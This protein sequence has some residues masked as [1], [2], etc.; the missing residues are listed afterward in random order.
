MALSQTSPFLMY[1]FVSSLNA[2][3]LSFFFTVVSIEL[4]TLPDLGPQMLLVKWTVRLNTFQATFN[5]LW[6]NWK[7]Q[8]LRRIIYET[9]SAQCSVFPLSYYTNINWIHSMSMECS[10]YWCTTVNKT[11][12]IPEDLELAFCWRKMMNKFT[13]NSR[14]H[15]IK[16]KTK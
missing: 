13:N 12:E 10:R 14:Q 3:T 9:Q 6:L 11:N 7:T 2:E 4:G 8:P 5:L 15:Y 1:R 16:I